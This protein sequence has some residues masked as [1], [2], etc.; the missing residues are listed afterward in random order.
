MNTFSR[1]IAASV[2]GLASIGTALAQATFR[3]TDL[4]TLS[5]Y[6]SSSAYGVSDN[7]SQVAGWLTAA[8]GSTRGFRWSATTGLVLLGQRSGET[9]SRA[10]AINDLGIA[11][12][13]TSFGAL[14]EATLWAGAASSGLGTLSN[15]GSSVAFAVNDSGQVAGWSDSTAG[16]RAFLWTSS[17][18]MTSLGALPGG[19][20][21]RAYGINASGQAVGWG[22]T[23]GGDRGFVSGPGGLTAIERLSASGGRT[24]AFG[25][26]NANGWVTG[27]AQDP[28]LGDVAFVYSPG[29]GTMSAGKPSDAVHSFGADVNSN[30]WAVGWADGLPLGEQAFLWTPDTGLVLLDN[31]LVS[32]GWRIQ[33]ARA[34]T[35]SG[36]IVANA[37]NSLGELRAVVLTPVPEPATSALFCLG[38]AAFGLHR[39]MRR[40]TLRPAAT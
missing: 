32:S 28:S 1:S 27:D 19:T 26:A 36:V 10:F 7:G 12:G 20:Q 4:G 22:T 13:E 25:N 5:G 39:R 33:R 24:R 21:T 23:P 2:L 31:L 29:T 15:S 37:V 16:T 11:V 38:L 35:D 40:V 3:V 17:G 34:I 9:S 30:G 18:A 8:N 6:A 14:R